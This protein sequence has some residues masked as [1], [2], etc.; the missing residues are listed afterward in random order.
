M[1]FL[2]VLKN[3]IFQY[4]KLFFSNLIVFITL[5]FIEIITLVFIG[6]FSSYIFENDVSD[7]KI[8]GSLIN[9][10][11]KY[12]SLEFFLILFVIVF[13]LRSIIEILSNYILL[14]SK[15]F[16]IES[17]IIKTFNSI[18]KTKFSFFKKFNKAET[19]NILNKEILKI[20]DSYSTLIRMTKPLIQI[21]MIIIIPLII[22]TKEIIFF[23]VV[24][25]LFSI[26][27]FFLGRIASKLGT[28][29][30]HTSN[31][32]SKKLY[33]TLKMFSAIIGLGFEKKA[34]KEIEENFMFHK[35]AA[36]KY[37]L[38]SS[39]IGLLYMPIGVIVIVLFFYFFKNVGTNITI[40]SLIFYSFY[41]LIPMIGAVLS[42][43]TELEG[44][45][46]A[47]Q[48]INEI[49]K[50]SSNEY[51]SHSGSKNINRINNIQLKNTYY[52]YDNK[53]YVLNNINLTIKQN[54]ILCITGHSGSGKSTLI[55]LII[56]NIK[57]QFGVIIIDN[58]PI[59]TISL[60]SYKNKISI[61][62]Q[63]TEFFNAS[64]LDN[65]K[66][67]NPKISIKELDEILQ[68]TDCISFI[69]KFNNGLETIIGD[70]GIELSGGEKQ[71]LS[72]ARA[73]TRNPELII[74]DEPTSSIDNFS[75]KNILQ[76]M[77]KI[78]KN[79]TLIIVSHKKSNLEIAD[80]IIFLNK[81]EVSGYDTFQG[82]L[83]KNIEFKKF[84]SS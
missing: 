45:Y 63:Q 30:L 74:L 80:D 1:F 65:L 33:D 79:T 38:L 2:N 21:P 84:F 55:D 49:K 7:N 58:A 4:P 35:K 72:I 15:Y 12:L 31:Q 18:T 37:H 39:S 75:E 64:I 8:I 32:F 9:Y 16:L 22:A 36:I 3:L 40:L 26:P 19:L 61:V 41:R 53:L 13:I 24:L 70:Q 17:N 42:N 27:I 11:S 69:S 76:L 60:D 57:P 67:F 28:E 62:P 77:K 5:G 81:G 52:S 20:G 56:G 78:S 10:S 50:F 14:K 23:G 66:W 51:Y 44:Y 43:K 71:K 25:F 54:K 68:K 73:L 46:P 6:S 47:H 34:S 48:K 29:D 82:L 59:E 83:D